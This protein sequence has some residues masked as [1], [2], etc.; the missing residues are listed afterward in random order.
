MSPKTIAAKIVEGL[1]YQCRIES[2]TDYSVAMPEPL[3]LHHSKLF[4]NCSEL[5]HHKD[6]NSVNVSHYKHNGN[7]VY[8]I[9]VSQVP[10]S[11]DEDDASSWEL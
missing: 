4:A 2:D 11:E 10:W 8:S 5:S 9:E 1:P 6:I 7:C 3:H